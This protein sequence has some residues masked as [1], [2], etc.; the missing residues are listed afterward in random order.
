MGKLGLSFE[1]QQ[2]VE[3]EREKET[4]NRLRRGSQRSPRE[5]R[6]SEKKQRTVNRVDALTAGIRSPRPHHFSSVLI[7]GL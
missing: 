6:K 7:H 4:L 5:T 2:L 1:E 3:C